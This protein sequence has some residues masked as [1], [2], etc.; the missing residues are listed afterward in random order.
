MTI[1]EMGA[2]D[3]PSAAALEARVFSM[4]WSENAFLQSLCRDDVIFLAACG[5]DGLIGYAGMYLALDEGEI[6]NIAVDSRERGRGI[7]SAL[8]ARLIGAAADRGVSRIVLEVRIS[9]DTAISLYKKAGFAIAGRRKDFYEK[10]VE[11]A[12]VMAL[13]DIQGRKRRC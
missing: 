2:A 6:M 10:P 13:D 9:N 4:P 5:E 11:D 12:Y 7:G 1:R 8:L 3:V